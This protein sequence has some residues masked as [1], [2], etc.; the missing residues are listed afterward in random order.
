MVRPNFVKVVT[1]EPELKMF[2]YN[3]IMDFEGRLCNLG[4]FDKNWL[5]G[6][7]L[8]CMGTQ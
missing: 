4:V 3:N 2:G 8:G 1:L 6:Q 7:L 5:L